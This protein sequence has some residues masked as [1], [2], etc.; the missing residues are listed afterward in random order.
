M[1]FSRKDRN[2]L[3]S[4]RAR[5]ATEANCEEDLKEAEVCAIPIF[6]VSIPCLLY[7]DI[8][9]QCDETLNAKFT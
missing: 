7:I 4:E 8:K 6:Q 1:E 2:G 3:L 5:K 9:F